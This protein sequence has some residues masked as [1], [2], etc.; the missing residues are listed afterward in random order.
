MFRLFLLVSVLL[1]SGCLPA[2]PTAPVGQKS[3]CAQRAEILRKNASWIRL[4]ATRSRDVYEAWEVVKT[5]NLE[6]YQEFKLLPNNTLRLV[7]SNECR[8]NNKAAW[9]ALT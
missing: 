7:K 6:A 8:S 9:C 2:I 3:A 1:V 5:R 4:E